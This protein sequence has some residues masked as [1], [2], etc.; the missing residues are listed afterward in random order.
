MNRQNEPTDLTQL[1]NLFDFEKEAAKRMSHSAYEYIASGAADEV[2]L[3]WNRQHFDNIKLNP[4]VL[5]DTTQ[6]DTA[7]SLFKQKHAYPIL[8][9]PTAYHKL[10]HPEGEIGTARGA[11]M[12]AT[13]YIISSYT[14]TLLEE[15]AQ[16]ATQ[17]LWFQMYVRDDREKT[18]DVIQKAESLG[19]QALVITVDTPVAGTRNR[20]HRINF[21]LPDHL[22]TPYIFDQPIQKKP[23]T[24]ADME[25][26]LSFSKTPVLLKGILN[27]ADAEKAIQI[28]ASGIIV[29]NH[30]GRNLDTVPSTIEVLPRI[31][32]KVNKRVPILMDGGIRRGTDVLKALALG[33]NAVL[34]GKPVC[35]GLGCGGA[36]GVAKVLT[37]LQTEF[38]QAMALVG[39]ARVG[40][41]DPSVIWR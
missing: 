36:A 26:V 4:S 29:S 34:V 20:E 1:V 28:G 37:I 32:D 11:G 8:V 16:A 19:C 9:A 13:T 5:V 30:G 39:K 31:V 17:P 6:L 2:T 22:H 41:I 40:D 14:T 7:I 10:T 23:L 12:A 35:Y 25:W 3:G 21:K 38:E 33:A 27:P 24:W 15:I 18:K